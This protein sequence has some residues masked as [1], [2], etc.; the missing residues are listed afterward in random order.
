M[1]R[2]FRLLSQSGFAKRIKLS[3]ARVTQLVKE[4]VIVL[5]NGKYVDPDQ[6]THAIEERI[7]RRRFPTAR[8]KNAESGMTNSEKIECLRVQVE[9][10]KLRFLNLENKFNPSIEMGQMAEI[11][12]KSPEERECCRGCSLPKRVNELEKLS[13]PKPLEE[14]V[15]LERR[16]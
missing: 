13:N 10:I 6:A 7:D 8:K 1:D 12:S 2:K 5:V 14:E 16:I 11:T 15:K 9:E 3:R 4:G